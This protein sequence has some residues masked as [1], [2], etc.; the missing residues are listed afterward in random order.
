MLLTGNNHTP[1]AGTIHGSRLRN[2]AFTLV[3]LT[4]VIVVIVIV[5]GLAAPQM[6][7]AFGSAQLRDSA[8]R[9]S[10]AARYARD[11]AAT[12]RR[13]CRIV[14]EADG[15]GWQLQMQTKPT[16][17]P[18]LFEP[19]QTGPIKPSKLPT[20][21][22]L[23][24][25]DVATSERALPGRNNRA[26]VFEPSGQADAAII[27]ITDG[28]RTWSLVISGLDGRATL[29]DGIVEQPPVERE[30]LDA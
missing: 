13:A 9:L 29:V 26:I 22:K 15:S 30:D 16:T 17:D 6:L 23:A 18:A 4:V 10:T 21:V 7:G 20:N 8:R 27:A 2:G 3:E 14:F 28:K 12:R 19:M 24:R 25:L 11:F 5:A 1:K